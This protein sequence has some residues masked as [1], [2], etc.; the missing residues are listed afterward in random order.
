MC[1]NLYFIL[2]ISSF[3]DIFSLVF[4]LAEVIK[5][6]MVFAISGSYALQFYVVSWLIYLRRRSD[7]IV[8]IFVADSYNLAEPVFP[9]E[10]R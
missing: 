2:N 10:A 5:I 6:M 1:K 3:C 7:V 8:Y 4:S 9:T